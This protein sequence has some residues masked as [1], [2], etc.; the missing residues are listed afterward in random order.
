[1]DQSFSAWTTHAAGAP[2][3][4]LA[5]LSSPATP[6]SK[7]VNKT[8]RERALHSTWIAPRTLSACWLPPPLTLRALAGMPHPPPGKAVWFP[9]S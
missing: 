8:Q 9:H 1:M 4:H 2:L 6:F 3:T 5:N 7:A